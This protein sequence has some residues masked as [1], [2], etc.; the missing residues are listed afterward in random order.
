MTWVRSVWGRS[1]AFSGAVAVV[2]S[3][4]V[5]VSA[6]AAGSTSYF[7]VLTAAGSTELQTARYDAV[8][9][10]LPNGQVLI[11]GGKSNSAVLQSAELFNPANDTFTALTAS[12]STE[13][14]TARQGAVAASL[15]N[16]EVLI[17][18]GYNGSSDLQ[19]AELFNPANDTFTAL[20]AAGSTELQTARYGALAAPL[21]NGQVLIAGGYNGSS[22]LQSAELYSPAPQAAVAGGDFGDQTVGQP[23]PVSVVVVTNVG[24]QTLSISA[25]S[26]SGT[27][28][29]DFAI[30]ADACSGRAL[31]FEQSCA[32]T[33]RFTPAT[34]ADGLQATITLSDNEP[35]A[36]TITLTGNGVAANSGP[37]GPTGSPGPAGTNGTTGAQG[38]AGTN[39][40]TGAQGPAGPR[41]PA[42]EVE[43]VT[44]KSVTTGK[45]KHKKTVQKC[46]TKLTS[47][48][49]KFSSARSVIAVVLSRGDVVY[50]TGSAIR[51]SNKTKLLL[52]PL[53][54][55]R[56]GSYTLTL[57]RGRNRQ[58][59]TITIA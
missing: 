58:R 51:A 8:A 17:A 33:A 47:S 15:P 42:G 34:A 27:N 45:G 32:I 5:A 12:G 53:H 55:I 57:T 35:A 7:S 39:G 4:V 41:G 31:A 20:P 23:S 40:T 25:T 13:L 44:C 11:A 54:Y 30:T 2:G 24:A 6:W 36:S 21:P 29:S 19:S 1:A 9:A 46:T 37:T 10:S 22:V 43:L 28:A 26:L 3:L 49:V 52:T 56:K 48:P 18:G 50:A 59:E 16:G 38:P 14:Q